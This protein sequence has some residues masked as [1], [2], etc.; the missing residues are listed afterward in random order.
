MNSMLEPFKKIIGDHF[1]TDWQFLITS[2]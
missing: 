2:K 1:N